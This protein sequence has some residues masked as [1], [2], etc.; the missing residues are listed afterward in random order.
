MINTAWNDNQMSNTADPVIQNE[1]NRRYRRFLLH[2][3]EK[4]ARRFDIACDPHELVNIHFRSI[5]EMHHTTEKE[6]LEVYA[7]LSK[8]FRNVLASNSIHEIK[9]RFAPFLPYSYKVFISD[10]I[11]AVK[12]DSR[13]FQAVIS[14]LGC[15][16]YECLMIGDSMLDDMKG[17]K[18]AG[19]R[20]CWYRRGKGRD[21]CEYADHCIDSITELPGLLEGKT[22]I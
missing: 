16:P 6:T 22:D 2:H 3:Y 1:W 8:R 18:S 9:G 11:Q 19:F 12:P 4:M 10:E 20:I 15:A 7:A 17:A 5:A 13:F 14:G 21:G